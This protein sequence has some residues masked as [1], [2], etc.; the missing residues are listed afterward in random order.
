MKLD[1][2]KVFLIILIVLLLVSCGGNNAA[3]NN[4]GNAANDDMND[5]AENAPANEP[6]EESESNNGGDNSDSAGDGESPGPE[7]TPQVGPFPVVY[8]IDGRGEAC[9]NCGSEVAHPDLELQTLSES[10][11]ILVRPN[12]IYQEYQGDQIRIFSYSLEQRVNL[13]YGAP[14]CQQERFAAQKAPG[15]CSGFLV[16]DQT[17]LTA[18]HCIPDQQA[19]E[20]TRIIFN[21]QIGS[22]GQAESIELQD[23]YGCQSVNYIED[24]DL[25]LVS[26]D[27]IPNLPSLI[28]SSSD[29]LQLG[30]PLA[31]VGHPSGLPKK[32]STDGFV[33]QPSNNTSYFIGV[34]DTFAGS[35]GSPVFDLDSYQ[36]VGMLVG[37]E[38]DYQLTQNSCFAVKLC[39][40]SAKDCSGE[41][42]VGFDSFID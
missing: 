13:L 5:A 6:A 20:N 39:Q 40:N 12:T 17:L 35:S 33:L 38:T 29:H 21:Y 7:E 10:V 34:L 24:A 27:R 18:E 31:V 42:I 32:I 9:E 3:N 11:A 22:D 8:G 26:L 41:L 19:C 16:N 4:A 1:Q 23:I 36:V 2:V 28:L 30:T 14:L 15:F 37:G 25:A